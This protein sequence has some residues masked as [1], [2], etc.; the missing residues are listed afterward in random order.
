MSELAQAAAKAADP[1]PDFSSDSDADL[2]EWMALGDA[3]KAEACA[4][5]LFSAP[6]AARVEAVAGCRTIATFG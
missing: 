4:A 2:F 1:P 5:Y 3:S 6:A